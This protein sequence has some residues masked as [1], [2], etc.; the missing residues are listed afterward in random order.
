MNFIDD[1]FEVPDYVYD[2]GC[3]GTLLFFKN[4]KEIGAVF[5]KYHRG[6]NY[7][8]IKCEGVSGD[9]IILEISDVN[10]HAVFKHNLCS[11]IFAVD[12]PTCFTTK[13]RFAICSE[14]TDFILNQPEM[15][16]R[17]NA[18]DTKKLREISMKGNLVRR[19]YALLGQDILEKFDSIQIGNVALHY[20]HRKLS[21]EGGWEL[22]ESMC[23][24]IEDL[25]E[26]KG[27]NSRYFRRP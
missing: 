9:C 6:F 21:L 16:E 19:S 17:F 13:L 26:G 8:A 7:R 14:D 2:T 25:M 1:F 5:S 15:L 27:E 3:T 22:L 23:Q 10:G 20:Y 4:F 24:A 18:A 11:D 12:E